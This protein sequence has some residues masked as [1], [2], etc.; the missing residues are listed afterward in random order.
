MPEMQLED[1]NKFVIIRPAT[2]AK[3]LREEFA[4]RLSQLQ[5]SCEHE[6]TK[7]M[8]MEWALGHVSGRGCVCL[9]C[10]KALETTSEFEPNNPKL[11]NLLKRSKRLR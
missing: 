11:R 3:S 6:K 10:E 4:N 5:E 7:W 2:T 1:N 9:R 8:N